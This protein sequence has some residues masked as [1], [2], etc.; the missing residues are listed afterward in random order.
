VNFQTFYTCI[1]LSAE[2]GGGAEG[3]NATE[4]LGAE[5]VLGASGCCHKFSNF[6][7]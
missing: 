1:V 2:F 4:L 6:V 7:T 3:H 5:F